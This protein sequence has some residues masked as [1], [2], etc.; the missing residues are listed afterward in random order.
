MLAAVQKVLMRAA[1]LPVGEDNYP[2]PVGKNSGML[3]KN[4]FH[5]WYNIN[6]RKHNLDANFETSWAKYKVRYGK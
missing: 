1:T 5:S 6:S 2:L 3:L 4:D